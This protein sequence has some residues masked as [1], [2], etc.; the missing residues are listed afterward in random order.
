MNFFEKICALL[1]ITFSAVLLFC[2][3][4]FPEFRAPTRLFT[5]ALIGVVVNMGLMV[6]VLKDLFARSFT[7]NNYRYFWLAAILLFWPSIIYYLVRHGFRPR[8]QKAL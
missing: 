8:T 4:S 2:L 3:L 5:L 6:V 1:A 7:D